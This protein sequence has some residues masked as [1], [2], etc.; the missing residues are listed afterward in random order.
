[1][2]AENPFSGSVEVGNL[3]AEFEGIVQANFDPAYVDGPAPEEM[4]VPYGPFTTEVEG[5]DVS[6]L[7]MATSTGYTGNNAEESN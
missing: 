2:S 1:M 4:T 6:R 3:G 5:L 7:P